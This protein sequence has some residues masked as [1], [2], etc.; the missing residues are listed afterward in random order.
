MLTP[1]KESYD[2]PRQHI[3]KQRHYFANKGSS[4]QGYG[5]SCGHVWMWELDCEEGWA[6]QNWCF[7]T[8]V[9]EKTL[10]S[11]LDCKEIQPVHSEGDQSWVFFGRTDAEAETPI[12]WPPHV[13]SWL[14]G[15]DPD[16]GRDWG[17]EEKGT[18]EDEMAEWHHRLNGHEFEWTPGVGD[19]QGGLA[20]YDSWGHKESDMTEQLN[21]TEILFVLTDPLF[22]MPPRSGPII[23]RQN[24]NNLLLVS[25]PL[26]WPFPTHSTSRL[27]VMS[28]NLKN[29][30]NWSLHSLKF[31]YSLYPTYPLCLHV[32]T[33][34]P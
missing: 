30:V 25:L 27:R 3:K 22:S 14:I 34:S 29:D 9:L 6:L 21:W 12:L 4:S 8:V 13:K 16:A 2:Q 10:E 5:F 23:S 18:T 17:Q 26:T 20:C 11:P 7:W 24:E 32:E 19:G 33:P 31:W 15:K 28:V 1:W